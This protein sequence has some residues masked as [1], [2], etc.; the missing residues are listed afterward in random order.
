[1]QNKI[2]KTT[3]GP[4]EEQYGQIENKYFTSISIQNGNVTETEEHF[5]KVQRAKGMYIWMHVCTLYKWGC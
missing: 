5:E 3:Q 2:L 1:M 4:K